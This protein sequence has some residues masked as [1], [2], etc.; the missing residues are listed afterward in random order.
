MNN[1]THYTQQNCWTEDKKHLI[2]W[3]LK[4]PEFEDDMVHFRGLCLVC[5]LEFMKSF[6]LTGLTI[7]GRNRVAY[8]FNKEVCEAN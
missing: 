3:N 1:M 7:I 6:S 2:K 5:K 4:N 8:D